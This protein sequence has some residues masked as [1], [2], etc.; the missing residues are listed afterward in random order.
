M[1]RTTL[2][3][4]NVDRDRTEN[5]FVRPPNY[6]YTGNLK[7]LMKKALLQKSLIKYRNFLQLSSYL[8]FSHNYFDSLTKLFSDV[9]VDKFFSR[10]FPRIITFNHTYKIFWQNHFFHV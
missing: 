3:I 6:S 2:L 1:E 7:A 9:Y 10:I 5:N 4:K 8:S